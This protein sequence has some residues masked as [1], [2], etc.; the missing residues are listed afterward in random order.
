MTCSVPDPDPGL[1]DPDRDPFISKQNYWEKLWFQLFC[2]VTFEDFCKCTVPT[3]SNKQKEEK[4]LILVGIEKATDEKSRIRIRIQILNSVY[5][6]KDPD[7][8]QTVTD[9]E[10][11]LHGTSMKASVITFFYVLFIVYP[12]RSTRLAWG[13]VGRRCCHLA[14]LWPAAVTTPSGYGTWILPCRPIPSTGTRTGTLVHLPGL[15]LLASVADPGC[16]S[17]IR[18]FSIPDPRQRI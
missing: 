3:V 17:R 5:G 13:T 1:Q 7:L 4:K 6:S 8:S 2:V 18:I 9:P 10:H 15:W 14:V 11:W 12:R 16:L